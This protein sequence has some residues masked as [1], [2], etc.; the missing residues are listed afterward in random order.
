MDAAPAPE[1]AA[2]D[3]EVAHTSML[4][5]SLLQAA[6]HVLD[7]AFAG[8]LEEEDW[9]HS[10]GGMHAVAL[11]GGVV[12]GHGAVVQRRLL[13]AGRP[14]RV[15]YVEGVAVHPDWQR[16]GVGGRLMERLEVVVRGGYDFGALG[17]S[18]EGLRLYLR[19]GWTV[20][21]G[22]LGAV[23]PEGIVDT[24]EEAGAVLVLPGQAPLDLDG[25]LLCD[26]RAGDLW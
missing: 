9:E 26:H 24:P 17:T 18:D 6:R 2:V 23:T 20:W 11:V 3:L 5:P 16:R 15:G 8:E 7:L 13:H 19:R 14:F 25:R 12:V 21:R 1:A 22:P 10:L 4:D